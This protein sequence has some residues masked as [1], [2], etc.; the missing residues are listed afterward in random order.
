MFG[1]NYQK[2]QWVTAN[3]ITVH[4]I[5][6]LYFSNFNIAMNVPVFKCL[7]KME[8][9]FHKSENAGKKNSRELMLIQCKKLC[10]N[11]QCK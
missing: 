2:Q 6:W 3:N 10:E 11:T 9:P 5:F 7:F 4:F 1:F 8:D